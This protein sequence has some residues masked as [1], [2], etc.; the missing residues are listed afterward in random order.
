MH[1]DTPKRQKRRSLRLK[2]YDYA[3]AGAYFVTIATRDRACLF[4]VIV[5]GQMCLN[6]AGREAE[7]CWLQIPQHF[8]NAALDEFI[9]MPNHVH[10]ILVLSRGTACRAPT[11]ERFGQ[12]V[13]GSL[14]TVVRS[15]KSAVTQR[16]NALRG[17]PNAS[18]WQRNYYE[19]VIRDEA[20]LQGIREY[21]ANNPLQW[22]L[23]RENPAHRGAWRIVPLRDLTQQWDG[24]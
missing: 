19:H 7:Q 11:I 22:A 10:G 20:S 9:V 6:A 4:G 5:D 1:D 3:Q 15:F 23:D 2:D 24:M 12:P 17:T 8:P 14:P 16:L 13:S 21:I 18:V